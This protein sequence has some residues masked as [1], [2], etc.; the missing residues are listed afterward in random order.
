MI[1][2]DVQRAIKGVLDAGFTSQ[3]LTMIVQ[4]SFNPTKQGVPLE[5]TVFFNKISSRRFGFQ[6]RK[7]VYD[8]GNNNFVKTESYFLKAT[9]QIGAMSSQ[10]LNDPNSLNTYDI[11]DLAA[12]ILQTEET[13][14][15]LLAQSIG[16]ERITDIRTPQIMIDTD[17]F[18]INANFDFVLSYKNEIVNTV[19]VAGVTGVVKSV[20]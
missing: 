1:D 4:Q 20:K 7:S 3:G 6:G 17:E 5:P 13:R 14:A 16:I 12:A 10:D 2:G 11:V 15:V 18:E 19:P 8:A 9:Y